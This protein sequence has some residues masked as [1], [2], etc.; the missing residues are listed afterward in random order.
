[1]LYLTFVLTQIMVKYKGH[2]KGKVY[3][4]KNTKC[5]F[6]TGDI[7][8]LIVDIC[9]HYDGRLTDPITGNKTTYK[10]YGQ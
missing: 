9:T 8:V 4:P 2:A 3:L 7:P 10:K 5:G 6:K 1:M